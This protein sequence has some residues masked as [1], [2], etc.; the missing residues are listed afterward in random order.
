[1][2]AARR[3]RYAV[4][5]FESWNLE[6]LLAVADAAEQLRSPVILGFSG[7]YLPHPD[8]RVH[9]RLKP[10]AAM[11]L[12][13]CK[14]L[15]VPASL[16]FNESPHQDWVYSAVDCGFNVVMLSDEEL[17]WAERLAAIRDLTLYAHERGVAVEAEMQA[18]VGVGGELAGNQ[19]PHD[20]QLTD[21][22]A[23]LEFVRQTGVDALA[24]NVGQVHLHGRRLV[25]LDLDRLRDLDK[26]SVPLALHG[27]SSVARGD[28]QAAI[29]LGVCKINV[30]SRLKQVYLQALQ[31]ACRA[32]SSTSNP[33]EV[34]GS[35]LEADVLVAGRVGMQREVE[36]YM[37]LFGSA[38]KI[39]TGQVATGI[40]TGE[41][42]VR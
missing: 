20:L 38:G 1:M 24:V 16:L 17:N 18:L 42:H 25:H 23:A 31:A 33:Y 27:A 36:E 35:G 5:Y 13:V 7:I 41:P 19:T 6:S 30:G 8:R 10:Y 40:A 29:E 4:G 11:G 26:I 12:E 14:S 9:D 32:V 15:S 39:A 37:K 22:A 21:P 28:L 3:G 2:T 34:I